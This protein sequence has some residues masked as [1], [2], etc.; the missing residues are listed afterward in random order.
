MQFGNVS[1]DV[2]ALSSITE[3]EFYSLVEGNL[4]TDKKDEWERFSNETEKYKVKEDKSLKV[5]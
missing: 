3:K 4:T 5:K 2:K 1:L